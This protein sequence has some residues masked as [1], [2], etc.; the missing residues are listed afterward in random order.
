MNRNVNILIE[1]IV[2]GESEE[3]I[4][5]RAIGQYHIHNHAHVLRYNESAVEGDNED[6]VTL[7]DDKDSINTIKISPGLVEMIKSGDNS[8]HMTFDLSQST[9][10]VY[11]T[12]YGSLYFQVDTSRIDIEADLAD[13]LTLHIEYSLSHGDSHISDNQIHIVVK[14]LN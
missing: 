3:R 10:S 6:K 1:G 2:R 4:V 12:P 11:D 14:D 9:Q 13:R 8:T 5:T 7:G